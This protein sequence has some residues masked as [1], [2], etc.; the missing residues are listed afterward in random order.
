[1]AISKSIVL[2]SGVTGEYL[3]IAS[4]VKSYDV[5]RGDESIVS[6]ELYLNQAAREGKKD[7]I[8][9]MS[10]IIPVVNSFAEAY[11]ELKKLTAYAEARDI[12]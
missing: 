1:M 8:T 3:R 6:V 11:V 10:E 9:I 7:K 4:I 12:L 5:S 2:K